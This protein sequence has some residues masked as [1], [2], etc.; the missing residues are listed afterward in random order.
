MEAVFTLKRRNN[1][2][3]LHDVK[4]HGTIIRRK[5]YFVIRVLMN[6]GERLIKFWQRII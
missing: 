2:V 4:S 3:I 5:M 6:Y 1:L